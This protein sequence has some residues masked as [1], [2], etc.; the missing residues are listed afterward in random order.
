MIHDCVADKISVKTSIYRPGVGF[1]QESVIKLR[2]SDWQRGLNTLQNSTGH[3]C[4]NESESVRHRTNP[5]DKMKGMKGRLAL[6]PEDFS[7]WRKEETSSD[8]IGC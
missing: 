8:V 7:D 6:G 2:C 5:G 4:D 3:A 1:V